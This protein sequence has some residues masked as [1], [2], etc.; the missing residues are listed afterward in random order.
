MQTGSIERLQSGLNIAHNG[1]VQRFGKRVKGGEVI[2]ILE[3]DRLMD[4]V[5]IAENGMPATQP[6]STAGLESIPL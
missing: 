4:G 5:E 1:V 6:E 2:L 3:S